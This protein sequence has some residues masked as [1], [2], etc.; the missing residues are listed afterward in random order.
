MS[1]N[2]KD[3]NAANRD[4]GY[5]RKVFAGNTVSLTLMQAA[6]ILFPLITLPYLARVLEPDCYSIRAYVIGYMVFI[7]T[8]IDFGFAQYGTKLVALLPR[9][10]KKLSS[11][12]SD[13]MLGKLALTA[14]SV[15]IV[16]SSCFF[17]LILKNNPVFLL[18]SFLSIAFKSYLPDFMLQGLED[19]KAIAIRVVSTQGVAVLL[20]FAFVHSPDQLNLVPTFEGAGAIVSFIWTVVYLKRRYD[21]G[22]GKPSISNT[23]SILKGSWP[24]FVSL[25]ASALMSSTV[26]VLMG[27]FETSALVIDCWTISATLIQGIQSLWQPIT[28]SLFPHM[29]K[30]KDLRL[31]KKLLAFGIPVVIAIVI[32]CYFAADWIMSIMGGKDYVQGSYILAYSVFIMPFSFTI[33]LIGYP[34]IGAIGKPS[35]LS[36][37]I[38]I[39][40]IVQLAV[41]LILGIAGGFNVITAI[42]I[43]I[44]S[45]FLLLLL[46][47][48]AAVKTIKEIP[49]AT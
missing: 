32:F 43:R 41:L 35:R 1:I 11:I 44:G 23:K 39:S 30:R 25:A 7:Q 49:A 21:V 6:K 13:V 22:F 3:I 27:V 16:V 31:L 8:L 33:A 14:L 10:P 20:I 28:R 45:E 18:L 9:Q 46:E 5:G 47:T 2:R 36:A 26:T 48:Y 29:V 24:F 12:N 4:I 40:G 19:M 15:I 37:C 38:G 17:I 42:V 34:L